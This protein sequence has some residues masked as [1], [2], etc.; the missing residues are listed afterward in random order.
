MKQSHGFRALID[1]LARVQK[2]ADS[3]PRNYGIDIPL[4]TSDIHL[5]D[6]I[7]RNPD[8]NLTEL[9]EM[10]W[11]SKM[12]I[13]AL[14]RK[15]QEKRLIRIVPGANKKELKCELA[16][17]GKIAVDTHNAY[18]RMEQVYLNE[19]MAQYTDEE[20]ALVTQV[21]KDYATYLED[22]AKDSTIL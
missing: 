3:I 13:S 4:K 16:E 6:L 22:Y 8:A 2:A 18:H 7:D 15:L 14:A 11:T 1:H 10:M 5:L 9:S 19:K 20:I 21:L 12:A 17:R